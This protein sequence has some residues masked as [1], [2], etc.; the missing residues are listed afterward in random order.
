MN[1]QKMPVVRPKVKLDFFF[2]CLSPFSNMAHAVLAR[3]CG[4][5]GPWRD[6]VDLELRPC[7][8]AG[9]I[10]Q[11][12]NLPPMARPW[13]ASMAKIH[14]QDFERNKKSIQYRKLSMPMQ[15]GNVLLTAEVLRDFCEQSGMSR[16]I[17]MAYV[18]GINSSPVKS[19]LS[20]SGGE[21]VDRG[22]FGAPTIFCSTDIDEEE[23]FFSV[24]NAS[25]SSVVLTAFHGL[26]AVE[27][28]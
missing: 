18:E 13:S 19:M 15:H 5:D 27:E 1:A 26:T 11:T 14:R 16:E 21:A 4:P 28:I 10:S 9:L 3:Y 8:L 7:L 17:S 20:S 6:I 23:A 12:G 2:D 25:S 22:A 24:A